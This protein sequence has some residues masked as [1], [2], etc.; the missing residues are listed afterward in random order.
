M[1]NVN[2]LRGKAIENGIQMRDLAD[3]A[4]VTLSTFYR[5]I[6]DGGESF[7]VKEVRQIAQRLKLSEVEMNEIF[8]EQVVA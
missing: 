8:F 5:R 4:G 1:L 2:K 3:A 6:A 7:T